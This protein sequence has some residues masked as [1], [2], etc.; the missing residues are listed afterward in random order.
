MVTEV[1]IKILDAV[2][3]VLFVLCIICSC[4]PLYISIRLLF[5]RFGKIYDPD[6]IANTLY[7]NLNSSYFNIGN[8]LR[9]S[10]KMKNKWH[11]YVND[12]KVKE[13]PY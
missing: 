7:T 5:E 1:I 9:R 2:M 8:R 11:I 6:Y 3:S 13:Y 10:K 4:V 12:V